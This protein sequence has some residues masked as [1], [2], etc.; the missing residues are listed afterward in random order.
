MS[1]GSKK[2]GFM[3]FYGNCFVKTSSI[4]DSLLLVRTDSL[5]PSVEE[6]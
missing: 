3:Q 1:I 6:S 4:S 5:K 2:S